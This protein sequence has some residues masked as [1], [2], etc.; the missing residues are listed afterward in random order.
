MIILGVPSSNMIILGVLVYRTE[1][2]QSEE[3]DATESSVVVRTAIYSKTAPPS[4]HIHSVSSI[5]RHNHCC[6]VG[7]VFCF[8]FPG[9]ELNLAVLLQLGPGVVRSAAECWEGEQVRPLLGSSEHSWIKH[10]MESLIRDLLCLTDELNAR[11]ME[12]N[13]NKTPRGRQHIFVW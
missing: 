6:T 12:H 2:L 5:Q 11:I 10:H 13:G 3:Q 7:D 1:R 4:L 9:G 8:M